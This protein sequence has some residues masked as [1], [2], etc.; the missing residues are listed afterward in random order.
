MS[1]FAN[2]GGYGIIMSGNKQNL[3]F[4]GMK[5][6]HSG[7]SNLIFPCSTYHQVNGKIENECCYQK[8]LPPSL[9]QNH[10]H[11]SLQKVKLI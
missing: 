6:N 3:S 11:Y 4:Q 7:T 1:H 5:K 2:A 10:G 8:P 9:F